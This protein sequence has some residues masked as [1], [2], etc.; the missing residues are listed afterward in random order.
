MLYDRINAADIAKGLIIAALTATSFFYLKDFP[1]WDGPDSAS[2]TGSKIAGLLFPA[3]IFFYTLT[4]PFS[5]TKKLNAGLSRF[6]I[7]RHIFAKGLILVTIGV[8]LVN[9]L[10][11]EPEQTGLNR[12]IWAILLIIAIFLVWNRYPD[13]ENSFFTT[14]GLRLAGLSILV[15]LV[16]KFKSGSYENNGSLIAGWWELPGLTGWAFILASFVYLFARNSVVW[17]AVALIAAAALNYADYSGYTSFFDRAEPYFGTLTTGYIPVIALSGLFTGILLRKF[18]VGD[19]LKTLTSVAFSGIVLLA[20]GIV[21]ARYTGYD[22][23]YGNPSWALLACGAS[24]LFLAVVFAADEMLGAVKWLE[25]IR[26]AGINMLS[27]YIISLLLYNIAGYFSLPLETVG[28]SGNAA[29]N[30][31]ASAGWAGLA[32]IIQYLLQKAGIRLKF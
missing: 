21:V 4:I 29:L 1:L 2:G 26:P 28:N 5:I 20:A 13:K 19:K 31:A 9:T 25:L 18:P 15:F 23:V 24:A 32:V 6:E 14:S 12:F 30:I 10:R 16:F 8:L 17:T 27:V 11:V 3:F 22:Q 7:S